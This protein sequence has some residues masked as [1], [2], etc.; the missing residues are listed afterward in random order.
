MGKWKLAVVAVG[1]RF[2]RLVADSE[3]RSVPGK[4]Y[5]MV[6]CKCDCGNKVDRP[7]AQLLSGRFT[8][9]N[10]KKY[11]LDGLSNT[12]TWRSWQGMMAR[13]YHENVKSYADY[14][15]RGIKVC[16]R[17]HDYKAFL[18]DLGERPSA[19]HSIERQNNDKDYEP[20]NVVWAT[21]LEQNNNTR[22]NL[23]LTF[24]GKEQ[25]LSQW[26]RELDLP[27]GTIQARLAAGWDTEKALSTPV[28]NKSQEKI[29][30]HNGI[31][32][33]LA[34]VCRSVGGDYPLV[35]ARMN[36]G[37]TLEEALTIKDGRK[38]R[39]PGGGKN[40]RHRKVQA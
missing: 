19:G 24:K 29:V 9:C 39:S 27:Y 7:A 3:P 2:G 22:K 13:C 23:R 12:P 38:E 25:T 14:G 5:R 35:K 32:G 1:Q 20:G 36:K 15:A 26:C 28:V 30:T 33:N 37:W 8:S 4:A 40:A 34:F 21:R 11:S 16:E 17:W 6:S 10:C 31:T 18:A